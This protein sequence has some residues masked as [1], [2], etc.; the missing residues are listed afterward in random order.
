MT[1]LEDARERLMNAV[2]RLEGAG[3]GN[4]ASTG[5]ERV[6]Q[7]ASAN[8]TERAPATPGGK[9]SVPRPPCTVR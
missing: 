8:P 3:R 9:A 5:G 2:A 1:R 6:Y 7:K 4:R